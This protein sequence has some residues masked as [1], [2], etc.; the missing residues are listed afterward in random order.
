MNGKENKTQQILTY[1][2]SQR[3]TEL[4]TDAVAQLFHANWRQVRNIAE[5]N[6][7]ACHV[8]RR[9]KLIEVYEGDTPFMFGTSDVRPLRR[10]ENRP[11]PGLPGRTRKKGVTSKNN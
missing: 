3:N 9:G 6:Q 7:E 5:A 4:D 11:H 2:S 1:L 8:T 10:A